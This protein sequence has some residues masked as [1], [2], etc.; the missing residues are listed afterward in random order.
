M[1][2][3]KRAGRQDK[4]IRRSAEDRRAQIIAAAKTRFAVSGFEGTTTRQIAD[5]MGVAQSLLLYHFESK[6]ELWKAVMTQIFE[7]VFLA[8]EQQAEATRD[9]DAR[10][11]LVAA[12]RGFIRMCLE[13][14]D[15]HR[16]MTMEGRAHSERLEW[17]A[18]TYLKPIHE[19]SVAL[20][21]QCQAASQIAPGDP[22]MIHY[23]ILGIGGTLFSFVPEIGLLSP[24]SVPPDPKQVEERICS[25]VFVDR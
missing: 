11:Q 24:S 15:L 5:D 2:V 22:T 21:K 17:L 9:Q 1:T 14:P 20:I 6:Y 23:T 12:I 4:R 18:R 8:A 19:R 10:S 7:H 3:S 16:L 25:A 13:E